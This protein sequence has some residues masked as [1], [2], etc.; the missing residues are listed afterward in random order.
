MDLQEPTTK[1]VEY[2]VGTAPST[3]APVF[4]RS[5]RVLRVQ[6]KSDKVP[7]LHCMPNFVLIGIHVRPTR[8]YSELN[9]LVDVYDWA[10]QEYKQENALILGDLNAAGGYFGPVDKI[11][12]ILRKRKGFRWLIKDNN[13]TNIKGNK[14][15]DRSAAAFHIMVPCNISLM[16]YWN[17][18]I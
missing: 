10:K 16:Q 11:Q 17:F 5:P 3:E 8:A 2:K 4:F 6:V 18:C 14:A 12:N 9:G 13:P 7:E 1:Q 15:Y